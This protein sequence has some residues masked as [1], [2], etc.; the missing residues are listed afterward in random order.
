MIGGLVSIPEEAIS[1]AD[2]LYTELIWMTVA[3]HNLQLPAALSSEDSRV[4]QGSA[5]SRSWATHHR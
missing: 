2:Q 1:H 3:S 4:N 5:D